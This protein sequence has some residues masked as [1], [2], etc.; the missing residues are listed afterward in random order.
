MNCEIEFRPVGDASRAGDAILI[1]YGEPNNYQLMIVDGG[2]IDSGKEL[3][4]HVR[5]LFGQNAVISHLVVTHADADHASGVREVLDGLPVQKLWIHAPWAVAKASL[6]Y[7]K[8]K[9]FTEAGLRDKLAAEYD[10]IAEIVSSA[11]AKQVPVTMPFAGAQIGPFVVLS[12]SQR[13]YEMLVPQFDR[14]PEPD[15]EALEAA[16]WW[17]SAPKKNAAF[18]LLQKAADSVRNW[19]T[20]TWTKER[21]RDGGQTS[22]SNESS[23]VLYGE[24][25]SAQPVLLTGDAGIV[26]LT[27]A[28]DYAQQTNRPLQQFRFV[29]IPHHGSR[30]NVGPTI[31]NRL[32]GPI[33]TEGTTSRFTAFV[34]APKEDTTHPRQMV[35]NAFMRRGGN[36]LATQGAAKVYYGGFPSR[37][38]YVAA[39]NMQFVAH[40]EDYD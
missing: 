25:P 30:R 26:A 17:L 11:S 36:V 22:A 32:L 18:A 9:R 12:P 20:E 7:F 13:M 16:G 5:A 34:S 29:Q 8:D 3:V 2:N 15:Q 33:Q 39:T 27:A 1:R 4:A 28:A 10:I 35:L 38:G 40:V 31:L 14:T 21:L 37:P 19:F 6:P 23:V 24:F